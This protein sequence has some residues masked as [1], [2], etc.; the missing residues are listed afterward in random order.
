MMASGDIFL[1]T[2]ISEAFCIAILE[3]AAS[4]LYVL[5]TDVGGISEILPHDLMTLSKC[6][7]E[8]L[9]ENLSEILDKKK[10]L[11]KKPGNKFIREHYNWMDISRRTVNVYEELIRDFKPFSYWKVVK[12]SIRP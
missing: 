8:S 5:S 1:N 4:G 6:T 10:Y 7:S 3:A 11:T 12:M 9:I 2:S